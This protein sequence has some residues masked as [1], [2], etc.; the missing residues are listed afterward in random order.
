MPAKPVLRVWYGG[1]VLLTSLQQDVCQPEE[2]WWAGWFDLAQR[3][4]Q[5]SEHPM[6]YAAPMI[7]LANQGVYGLI[8]E[9]PPSYLFLEIDLLN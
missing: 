6:I 4:Q 3:G 5:W 8:P 9:K 7:P 2:Y 1:K